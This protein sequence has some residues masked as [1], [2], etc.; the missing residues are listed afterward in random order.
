MSHLW[1]YE[2]T[3]AYRLF[4][5]RFIAGYAGQIDCADLALTTLVEFAYDNALPLR[6][7]YYDHG[8]KTYDSVAQKSRDAYRRLVT[9]NMGALNVIDNTHA[10]R[11][12]DAGPGD[13]IMTQWDSHLGHT[14]IIYEMQKAPA[15]GG[16][17][18]YD[19]VWYQGNLPPVVPQRRQALFSTIG[20]VYGSKPRRWNFDA[21]ER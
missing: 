12:E 13:L 4:A 16:A 8:W 11:L 18:D 1:T 15:A 2:K 21:F 3:F 10:I 14:R 5:K 17:I 7:K 9:L 20:H 19:V 6:L